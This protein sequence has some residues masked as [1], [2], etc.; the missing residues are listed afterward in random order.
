MKRS[1][2]ATLL[3]LVTA[4]VGGCGPSAEEAKPNDKLKVPNIQ[5][6]SQAKLP[7]DPGKKA[8]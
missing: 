8:R 4:L 7:K 5:P 2:C 1:T 3:A 6:A